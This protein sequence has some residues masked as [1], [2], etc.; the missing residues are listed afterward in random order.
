MKM[1]KRPFISIMSI[2]LA[3]TLPMAEPE[4]SRLSVECDNSLKK[5]RVE[6]SS[7]EPIGGV[8]VQNEDGLDREEEPHR[9]GV[10]IDH[11]FFASNLPEEFGKSEKDQ[12]V[13]CEKLIYE[14]Q[15]ALKNRTVNTMLQEGT[16]KLRELSEHEVRNLMYLDVSGNLEAFTEDIG[17]YQGVEG[18]EW[19]ALEQG[20]ERTDIL[21]RAH[22]PLLHTEW[23]YYYFRCANNQ[24]R[25]M[26]L[27]SGKRIDVEANQIYFLEQ[28]GLYFMCVPNE[29]WSAARVD[30]VR[31]YTFDTPDLLGAYV[32]INA[33]EITQVF[34]TSAPSTALGWKSW[35]GQFTWNWRW[36]IEPGE[37]ERI[38]FA[39]EEYIW[40]FNDSGK[41][42]LMNREKELLTDYEYEYST[43]SGDGIV[44][45]R[46]SEGVYVFLDGSG[47]RISPETY[48]GV[49]D[50]REGYAAVRKDGLWG[51][52]DTNGNLV[53]DYRFE[54]IE[55]G[56]SEGKAPVKS[57]GKWIF[58][59][60]SGQQLFDQTFENVRKFQEG[61][62]AVEKGGKWGFIDQNGQVTIEPIYEAVGNF[63]EGLAAVQMTIDGIAMWAYI[64]PGNEIVIDYYPYDAAGNVSFQIGEFHDGHAYVTET[65]PCLIDREGEMVLGLNSYFLAGD[66]RNTNL[67]IFPAYDYEDN[68]MTKEVCGMM[69]IQG[70][71]VVP[72]RFYWVSQL[73][74]NLTVVQYESDG[75]LLYGI[76][77]INE[78][79]F[80]THDTDNAT[81]ALTVVYD[82]NIALPDSVS[83]LGH[84]AETENYAIYPST[85]TETFP[86]D[87]MS[88]E[89][90]DNFLVWDK[91]YQAC[92]PQI[93]YRNGH[94]NVGSE[95]ERKINEELYKTGGYN[96]HTQSERKLR[97]MREDK[98]DYTITKADENVV[99]M[100]ISKFGVDVF[101]VGGWLQGITIDVNT[102]EPLDLS[103]FYSFEKSPVEMIEKGKIEFADFYYE[104]CPDQDSEPEEIQ[105]LTYEWNDMK[106]SVEDFYEDYMAGKADTYHCYFIDDGAV[107]ILIPSRHRVPVNKWESRE[108]YLVLHIPLEGAKSNPAVPEE[109]QKET[110][111]SLFSVE[112]SVTE[113]RQT[114]N[115]H[116]AIYPSVITEDYPLNA[117]EGYAVWKKIINIAFPQIYYGNEH[118]N[119]GSE[120]ESGIN[121]EM[122][123]LSIN[124]DD[125]FLFE[126]DISGLQQCTTDYVITKDDSGIFSI[127]FT[128]QL[129]TTEHTQN[130]CRGITVEA[131]TGKVFDLSE[132][133]T[134]GTDLVGQVEN[135]TIEFV[136]EEYEWSDVS[137]DVAQFE[138]DCQAGNVDTAHCYYMEE[139][140]VN[141]IVPLSRESGGYIVLRILI[142]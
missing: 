65:I 57:N 7:L 13:N 109:A 126:R 142:S 113:S 80:A 62:A 36:F 111:E 88:E 5:I 134:L 42:A 86:Q 100:C 66:N 73:Y 31:L 41:C 124:N 48:E 14:L 90:R 55:G 49:R 28:D 12:F 18:I 106:S 22:T 93:Y 85:M 125:S 76:I 4:E 84:E 35:E 104:Y 21:V 95:T 136:S 34:Y 54:D 58:I 72:F 140:A 101:S 67:D 79:E 6:E 25:R 61:Y 112:P 138:K 9:H 77:E 118:D 39:D 33:D 37:Y 123:L 78:E 60:M 24:N 32:D 15:D 116:Y 129:V 87:L 121:Q 19:Y 8:L 103:D 105:S 63:S 98:A 10:G 2:L 139:N 40:V 71:V 16:G 43:G 127:V 51:F 81:A 23:D 1:Y 82:S 59:D 97:N 75:E 26:Y 44:T 74:G 46:L 133:V 102:G 135:G 70:N 89:V 115:I 137:E 45:A 94:E 110:S 92:F 17:R 47:E 117:S 29:K 114:D 96:E 128:E 56:F 20:E 120:I 91:S 131:A 52:I 130:S 122:F 50:F 11:G 30:S 83:L 141:L 27:S 68:M 108:V 119:F 132:C 99:S 107:N 38:E 64:N 69:D 3:C 53:I